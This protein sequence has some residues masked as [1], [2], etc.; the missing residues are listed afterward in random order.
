MKNKDDQV[1]DSF[2]WPVTVALAAPPRKTDHNFKPYAVPAPRRD[3]YQLHDQGLYSLWQHYVEFC[4]LTGKSQRGGG[5]P[6]KVSFPDVPTNQFTQRPRLSVF[7]LLSAANGRELAPEQIAHAEH[8]QPQE[9]MQQLAPRVASPPMQQQ[10]PVYPHQTSP[11]SVTARLSFL[12]QQHHHGPSSHQVAAAAK[13]AAITHHGHQFHPAYPQGTHHFELCGAEEHKYSRHEEQHW[14]HKEHRHHESCHSSFTTRG[15]DG[16][17]QL[18]SSSSSDPSAADS[19]CDDSV[20]V[21]SEDSAFAHY[22][23]MY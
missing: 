16:S 17:P 11:T 18:W 1:A 8:L 3:Q 20:S 15:S 10:L 21:L 19:C 9:H 2:F 13:F 4:R 6:A 22:S 23:V 14:H 5:A 7:Q 12:E